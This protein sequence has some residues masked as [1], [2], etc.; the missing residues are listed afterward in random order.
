MQLDNISLMKI[1]VEGQEDQV[2]SGAQETILRCKPVILI[3]IMG[4]YI[5]ATAPP[6]VQKQISNT[7]SMLEAMGYSVQQVHA[8][9]YL[10]IPN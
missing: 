8:H 9:D 7:I 2:L 10:A 4:G 1:D 5:F 6:S 3:E